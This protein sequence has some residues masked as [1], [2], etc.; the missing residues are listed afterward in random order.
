[1]TFLY[2]D[3]GQAIPLPPLGV[4]IGEPKRRPRPV[5]APT[6]WTRGDTTPDETPA[7]ERHQAAGSSPGRRAQAVYVSGMS[8]TDLDEDGV[9]ASAARYLIDGGEED[10]ASV[11]LACS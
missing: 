9:Q 1:L 7:K 6:R 11:L 3:L 8:A 5:T 4:H 2:S 10:A